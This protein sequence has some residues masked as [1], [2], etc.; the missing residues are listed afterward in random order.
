MNSGQKIADH[1]IDV[2]KMIPMPKGTEKDIP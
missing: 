1:F 2:N